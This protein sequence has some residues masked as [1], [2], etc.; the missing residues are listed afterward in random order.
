MAS[1]MWH[2]VATAMG[3]PLGQGDLFLAIIRY[4][5]ILFVIA[6]VLVV[7]WLSRQR[8]PDELQPYVLAALSDTEALPPLTIRQRPPLAHQD[9]D[10]ETLQRVLETLCITGQAVRWYQSRTP[11]DDREAVYRRVATTSR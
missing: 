3:S 10:L 7:V 4:A 8:L 2:H 6:G 9:I 11:D 5:P 1:A